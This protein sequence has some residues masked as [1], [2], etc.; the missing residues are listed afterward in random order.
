VPVEVAERDVV[1]SGASWG[2][3]GWVCRSHSAPVPAP[4]VIRYALR[5]LG[6]PDSP[7]YLRPSADPAFVRWVWR[8]WRSCGRSQFRRGYAAVAELNRTTFDLFDELADAGVET[9]LRT[10]GIVHA[11]LSVEE[12]RHHL[13]VQRAMADSGYDVPDDVSVGDGPLIRGSGGAI[14]VDLRPWVGGRPLLPDGLRVLDRVPAYRNAFVAT[15]HGMLGITL[16]PASGKAL[17][18]YLVTGRRP[19]VLEP[20]RFDRLG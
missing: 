16:A 11:F 8:F 6:R 17:A 1:A 19:E 10:P 4:G 3:A 13:S 9:T 7:L 20:F 15:G 18:E 2:N 14:R 5:S 12:A